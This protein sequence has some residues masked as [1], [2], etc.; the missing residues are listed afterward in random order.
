MAGYALGVVFLKVDYA[1]LIGH[2]ERQKIIYAIQETKFMAEIW[3]FTTATS[4]TKR[5][6]H[7]NPRADYAKT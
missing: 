1:A 2:R 5:Q 3:F 6:S 4:P 7:L